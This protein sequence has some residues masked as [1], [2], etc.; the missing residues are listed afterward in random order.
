MLLQRFREIMMRAQQHVQRILLD[1]V[2]RR[3]I[4]ESVRR[5][6]EYRSL[7]RL[8]RFGLRPTH[9]PRQALKGQEALAV[10]LLSVSSGRVLLLTARRT[11]IIGFLSNSSGDVNTSAS[12]NTLALSLA[13]V[14][15]STSLRISSP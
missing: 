2:T 4:F 3:C 13:A 10:E 6:F 7:A 14:H 8:A 12:A 15:S 1:R 9:L 11:L 5:R